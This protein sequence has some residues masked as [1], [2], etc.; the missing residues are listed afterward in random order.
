M[1]AVANL[2]GGLLKEV[3]FLPESFTGVQIGFDEAL[4]VGRL[5][6]ATEV[7][8]KWIASKLRCCLSLQLTQS[9][10]PFFTSM[11]LDRWQRRSEEQQEEAAEDLLPEPSEKDGLSSNSPL[12]PRAGGGRRRW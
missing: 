4:D 8:L 11:V 6:P 3:D 5:K 12:L 1:N 2:E 10:P 7:M 9:M